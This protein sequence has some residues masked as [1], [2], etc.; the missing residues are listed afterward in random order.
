[1][2]PDESEE[3]EQISHISAMGLEGGESECGEEVRAVLL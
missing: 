3:S 2:E 1:M